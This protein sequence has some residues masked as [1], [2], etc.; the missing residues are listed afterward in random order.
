MTAKTNHTGKGQQ[1]TYCQHD[2]EVLVYG[3]DH[4]MQTI[5]MINVLPDMMH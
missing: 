5:N 1:P 4:F 2:L 3:N